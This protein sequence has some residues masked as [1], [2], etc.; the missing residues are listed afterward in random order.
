MEQR[1]NINSQIVDEA[2]SWFVE[3]RAGD[4]DEAGQLEFDAWLRRSPEHLRAYLEVAAIWNEGP[5]LD[6]TNKWDAGTLIA[7]AARDPDNVVALNRYTSDDTA[8]TS[9]VRSVVHNDLPRER[10]FVHLP[11]RRAFVLAASLAGV[12]CAM[13]MWLWLL[14]S[15]PVYT[16]GVGE[17]RLFKLA[18]SST[19]EMNS[20]SRIRVRYSKDER[21]VDLLAGQALFHVAKGSA[22][23]FI[24]EVGGTRV[25]AVGTQF[26]V[27]KKARV[28][29]V[30]VVEGRVSV[31][32]P[33]N[34]AGDVTQPPPRAPTQPAASTAPAPISRA[35]DTA[36]ARDR[37]HASKP[38]GPILV[39]AGE[40]LTVTSQ[41]VQLAEHANITAATAW[42]QRQVVFDSA[43]LAEVAEEFNRYNSRQVIIDAPESYQFHISGVFSST[44][45]E[46]LIRFLRVRPDVHVTET[47]SEI[48]IAKNHS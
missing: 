25:R 5:G 4:L 41:L 2:S 1:T 37:R 13:A 47:R 19:V 24:V 22:R 23:P 35:E 6:P 42:T 31:V 3:C 8:Q 46:S 26:D 48:R 40:Q 29:I 28:T 39:S 16:T 30:T 32:A 27:Y 21:A 11:R 44:D 7:E 43:T 12:S 9:P 18:D 17:Q 34:I 36:E 14:M 20:K 10:R 33:V 38:T 45:P 15:S